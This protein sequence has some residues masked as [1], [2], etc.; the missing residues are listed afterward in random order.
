M[1]LTTF[2][3]HERL[4]TQLATVLDLSRAPLRVTASIV[5]L[6]FASPWQKL[7][8]PGNVPSIGAADSLRR[9]DDHLQV[10]GP[11]LVAVGLLGRPVGLLMLVL[12][13]RRSSRAQ[14]RTSTCSGSIVWL[15]R[16]TRSRIPVARPPAE[17]RSEHSPLPCSA[18]IA[19]GDW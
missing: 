4:R 8:L 15:V 6:W 2:A 5:D 3:Q 12:P 11:I 1:N 18:P 14:R 19:V 10:I 17:Q 16:R 9:A 13:C 7:S